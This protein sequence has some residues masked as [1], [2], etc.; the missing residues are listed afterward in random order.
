MLPPLFRSYFIKA[1]LLG[2]EIVNQQ[3]PYLKFVFDDAHH[4]TSIRF[5]LGDENEHS[6]WDIYGVARIDN[7]AI[8][9]QAERRV[10]LGHF[11]GKCGARAYNGR[12]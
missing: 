5:Q 12:A 9:G 3:L 1:A 8:C 6:F 4:P 7:L 10:L 2:G 11:Y